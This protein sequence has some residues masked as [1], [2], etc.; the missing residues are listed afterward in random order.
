MERANPCHMR[1]FLAPIRHRAQSEVSQFL[2]LQFLVLA[3]HET[4]EQRV[5]FLNS[6]HANI[7]AAGYIHICVLDWFV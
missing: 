2:T 6:L 7:L 1:S 5:C 4:N 3:K